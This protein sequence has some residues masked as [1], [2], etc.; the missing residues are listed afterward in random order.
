MKHIM[1]SLC[2]VVLLPSA[3]HAA[4]ITAF[5]S[6]ENSFYAISAFINDANSDIYVATYTF[7][8][9]YIARQLA[10]SGRNVIVIAEKSPAGGGE[11]L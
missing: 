4:A 7:T 2:I 5:S 9:P 11:K 8:S 6:P 3:A 10:A 1:V